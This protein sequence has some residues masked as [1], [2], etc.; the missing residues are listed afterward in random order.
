MQH[1]AP[2]KHVFHGPGL[3][4]ARLVMSMPRLSLANGGRE[5]KESWRLC[6]RIRGRTGAILAGSWR[7]S[8]GRGCWATGA[9]LPAGSGMRS[10]GSTLRRVP[11]RCL[12]RGALVLVV[13][14]LLALAGAACQRD[15]HGVEG[16]WKASS[17]GPQQRAEPHA[18]VGRP[19]RRR[20]SADEPPWIDERGVRV[21]RPARD[22]GR[23]VGLDIA[24]RPGRR[25]RRAQGH[26]EAQ[27]R[28]RR[29]RLSS[30]SIQ[31]SHGRFPPCR[32]A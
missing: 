27:A 29:E 20:R 17:V 15:I 3:P 12:D 25:G 11:S 13:V 4:M 9:A 6:R 26:R 8:W 2:I 24:A 21:L 18:V 19:P 5:R 7:R 10:A 16:R 31:P 32:A 1:S 14:W 30:R 23:E 28:Q 22:V